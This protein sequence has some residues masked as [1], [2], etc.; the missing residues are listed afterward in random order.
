MST[1][2][3]ATSPKQTLIKALL[4]ARLAVADH[5]VDPRERIAL[6]ERQRREPSHVPRAVNRMHGSHRARLAPLKGSK[7]CYLSPMAFHVS[8][9]ALREREALGSVVQRHVQP[10]AQHGVSAR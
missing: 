1:E 7:G 8:Q 10:C 3:W 5:V 4:H 2:T 6:V 9:Q